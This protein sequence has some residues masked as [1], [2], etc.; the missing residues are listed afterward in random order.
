MNSDI[1]QTISTSSQ[2]QFDIYKKLIG[3]GSFSK[4][5]YGKCKPS[6]ELIAAKRCKSSQMDK[7]VFLREK[8]ILQTLSHINIIH[9]YDTYIHPKTSDYWFFLEFCLYGDLYQLILG[10]PLKE[11]YIQYFFSQ[12]T[13]AVC[14]LRNHHIYHRDLKP[15]NLLITNHYLIKLTDFGFSLYDTENVNE[16]LCG[17]PL[18]M[19]PELFIRN[20][21]ENTSDLW[22]LGVILFMM[23]TGTHLFTS[24]NMTELIQ[25]HHT[26][27]VQQ[28]ILDRLQS[29][30]ELSLIHI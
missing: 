5:Y 18:Y 25:A 7:K 9:L 16:V 28:Q 15:Q 6:Q 17:S 3:K 29:P 10:T 21:Y 26:F 27:S 4:I 22:S 8:T 23:I 12:I 14:Y 24:Q 11:K 30:Y 1:I 13:N 2:Q 19:A 20:H